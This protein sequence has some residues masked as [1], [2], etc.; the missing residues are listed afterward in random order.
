MIRFIRFNNVVVW[1][2]LKIYIILI[3]LY[4][5]KLI[6]IFKVLILDFELF[7]YFKNVR[8]LK[9]NKYFF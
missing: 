8:K 9:E 4:E 7:F 6:R 5:I 2:R 3:G 1:G